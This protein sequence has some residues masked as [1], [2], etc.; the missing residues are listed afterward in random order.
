[1]QALFELDEFVPRSK[2][3]C[4]HSKKN[5]VAML[6]TYAGRPTPLTFANRL[7]D[8]YADAGKSI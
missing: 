7:T 3:R 2:T 5:L 8:H 1:M 6:R 4:R